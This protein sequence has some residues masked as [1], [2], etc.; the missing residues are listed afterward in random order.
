MKTKLRF[1]FPLVLALGLAACGASTGNDDVGG[2]GATPDAAIPPAT[3]TA[4][5]PIDTAAPDPYVYVVIQDTEQVACT[6][7]GPGADIDSV[8][9]MTAAGVALGYGKIGTAIFYPNPA[10]NACANADCSGS[11]CKYA[12]ISKT[13]DPANLVART[14]GPPDAVVN[15]A[16]DDV[17]YFSLNAG[18][19]QLQIGDLTGLGPAQAITAGQFIAVSEVD[20]SYITAGDAPLTCSCL[21]EHYTVTLQTAHGATLALKPASLSPDNIT[22]APL[23]ATSTD[24][25]GSTVFL[26][27]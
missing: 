6:T 11:N 19:L 26:V 27:P 1:A 2:G 20:K 15:A 4:P 3:D 5:A 10:G 16:T 25:C 18:T 24:G 12:Y 14:E 8:E 7:N 22:C 9:L 17:G 13:L 21:P 23:T